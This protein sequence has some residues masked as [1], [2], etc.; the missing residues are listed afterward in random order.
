[1]FLLLFSV[2]AADGFKHSL[3]HSFSYRCMTSQ[4]GDISNVVVP[5][6]PPICIMRGGHLERW[7]KGGNFLPRIRQRRI[8]LSCESYKAALVESTSD[9]LE[10]TWS[11]LKQRSSLQMH[12]VLKETECLLCNCLLHF[13]CICSSGVSGV[14]SNSLVPTLTFTCPEGTARCSQL[15]DTCLPSFLLAF[16][17]LAAAQHHILLC[18]FIFFW[19]S[20]CLISFPLTL[21]RCAADASWQVEGKPEPTSCRICS[22]TYEA[23]KARLSLFSFVFKANTRR[24]HWCLHCTVEVRTRDMQQEVK[25]AGKRELEWLWRSCSHTADPQ[26]SMY[27]LYNW[28]QS[29]LHGTLQ[30]RC[31]KTLLQHH[32]PQLAAA[33]GCSF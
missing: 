33:A 7:L 24:V 16:P 2:H 14:G 31:M 29:L 11:T 12:L 32:Q 8:I 26:T 28:P 17:Q 19:F 30:K 21:L 6:A 27:I 13:L 3:N 1:M 4:R 20:F 15:A 9:K 22:V 10:Q 25:Q 5:E 23:N 18:S